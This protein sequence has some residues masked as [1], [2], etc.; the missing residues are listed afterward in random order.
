VVSFSG[1]R[2]NTGQLRLRVVRVTHGSCGTRLNKSSSR[3]L[4]PSSH[5]V[6]VIWRCTSFVRSIRSASTL[7]QRPTTCR[8]P[9]VCFRSFYLS[10]GDYGGDSPIDIAGTVQ[11]LRF[12]S[13][14]DQACETCHRRTS[15]MQSLPLSVM[16]HF[17]LASFLSHRS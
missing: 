8:R 12:G 15:T 9:P 14:A 4:H 2:P 7:R 17:R 6:L 1:R 3:R 11:A 5:S 13:G 10:A 16:R